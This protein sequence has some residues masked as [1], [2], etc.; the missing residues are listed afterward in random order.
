MQ[1]DEFILFKGEA[2]KLIQDAICKIE[3]LVNKYDEKVLYD[4]Y[5]DI[6][7]VKGEAG[8]F[9]LNDVA[10]VLHFVE[11]EINR[12]AKE[13]KVV[14]EQVDEIKKKLLFVVARIKS[15]RNEDIRNEEDFL[16]YVKNFFDE[17][18]RYLGKNAKLDFKIDASVGENL[19]YL[20]H[21]VI[22][23]LR[24]ALEHAIEFPEQRKLKNKDEV[25]KISISISM[26]PSHRIEF[27]YR[28]DGVGFPEEIVSKVNSGD[29]ESIKGF[30]SSVGRVSIH[31]GRG[32][33]LYSIYKIITSKFCDGKI[34]IRSEKDRG[35]EINITFLLKDREEKC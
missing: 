13:G 9:K 29:I 10:E 3:R 31:S 16:E 28:D 11:E 6:H 12:L 8:F 20:M 30:S 33:G 2:I 19:I 7:T 25:G 23:L 32:M 22:G 15:I 21:I 34:F 4:A 18:A 24:N 26:L 35:S 17:Y 1:A 27:Y 5:S 14:E